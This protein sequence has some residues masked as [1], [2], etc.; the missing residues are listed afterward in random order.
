MKV[1]LHGMWTA[2]IGDGKNYSMQLPGTLDENGIGYKDT[3]ANQWHPDADLGN[4]DKAFRSDEIAT[5]FTRRF[6][7]E[8]EARLTRH[9]DTEIWGAIAGEVTAGKRVFLDVERARVLR[10]LVD[11]KEVPDCVEPS[12]STVHTFELT[13]L[14][15]EKSELTLISDNSYSGLPRDA[16]VYS[17][18]ATAETQ[19]NWNGV[20][21]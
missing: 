2:D 16:I 4:E 15:N 10:L 21:G 11:G 1:S 5:R 8:G 7:Y 12:V 18:A 17:S 13:G 9:I 19:T 14:L 20:L 3:G 6:T